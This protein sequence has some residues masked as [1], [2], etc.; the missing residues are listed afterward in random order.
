[1]TKE[2]DERLVVSFEKIA[3]ALGGLN[4]Q[5]RRAGKRYWPE[6][7]EQKEAVVSR[8]PTEEDKIK[9]RQGS[10]NNVPIE[11]WLTDLGPPEDDEPIGERT[12]QWIEDHKKE[13]QKQDASAEVVGTE[14]DP[15]TETAEGQ[16]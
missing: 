9:E 11:Q 8:V 7:R 4:E 5:A 2:Q 14:D 16:A 1:M 15:S 12:R 3:K 13:S 10:G 6:P